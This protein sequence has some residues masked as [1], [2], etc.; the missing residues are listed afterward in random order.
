MNP[1]TTTSSKNDMINEGGNVAKDV[2][3]SVESKVNDYSSDLN[4]FSE[5]A[6]KRIGQVAS[7]VKDAAEDYI[8]T[9]SDYLKSGQDY[10]KKNPERSLVYAIGA[11][12]VI[13][14][15]L[16]YAYSNQKRH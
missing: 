1:S 5:E 8:A 6:G 13:G 7:K 9:G 4:K 10:V 11:G 12:A 16:A 14:G 2:K 3:K 15:F